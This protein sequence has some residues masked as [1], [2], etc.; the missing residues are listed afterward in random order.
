MFPQKGVSMASVPVSEIKNGIVK[1]ITRNGVTV[2][3]VL[4][5]P[6]GGLITAVL[7]ENAAETVSPVIGKPLFRSEVRS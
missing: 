3:I 2:E 7:T 5:L 6:C 4:S 1:R